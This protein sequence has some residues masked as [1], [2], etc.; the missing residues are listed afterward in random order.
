MNAPAPAAAGPLLH[1]AE[2]VLVVLGLVLAW[3]IATRSGVLPGQDFPPATEIASALGADLAGAERWGG[4]AAS[5]SAWALGMILVIVV[6][7][8][9]GMLLGA[10]EPSYRASRL[11][12]E[13]VRTLPA[14]A[15]LPLLLFIHGIG[16][17]LTVTIVVLAALWPLLIQSMYGMRDVDPVA[18]A[19]ARVYGNEIGRA[20]V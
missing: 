16:Q 17:E 5:M 18:V 19:T 11:T 10:S 20:P 7:V 6:G 4:I 9:V 2:P 15:A 12:L 14:I 8:P 13:F 1:R 3:E